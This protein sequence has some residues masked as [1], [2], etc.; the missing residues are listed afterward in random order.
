[1]DMCKAWADQKQ[2]GV[3]EGLATGIK[4]GEALKLISQVVKKV[5]KG[6]TAEEIADIFEEE[7]DLIQQIYNVVEENPDFTTKEIYQ[8]MKN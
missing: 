3:E 5:K 7:M 4:E 8:K 1:M 2:C 6:L